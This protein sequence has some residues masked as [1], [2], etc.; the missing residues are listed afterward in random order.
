M[1]FLVQN[2]AFS[3]VFR[4]EVRS[5]GKQNS[6]FQKNSGHRKGARCVSRELFVV[7]PSI[8]LNR[9]NVQPVNFERYSSTWFLA[10]PTLKGKPNTKLEEP[11]CK[12]TQISIPGDGIATVFLWWKI[13]IPVGVPLEN[14][15]ELINI[16]PVEKIKH[17]SND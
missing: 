10:G 4:V 14:A 17:L 11:W 1:S 16:D 13:K 8:Q 15:I 6:E 2:L 7:F 12:R 3:G 9:E 5:P